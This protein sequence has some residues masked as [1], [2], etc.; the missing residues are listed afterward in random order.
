MRFVRTAGAAIVLG[1]LIGACSGGGGS[2]PG[3]TVVAAAQQQGAL[4]AARACRMWSE[5]M[6]QAVK[7]QPL[8]PTVA[9]PLDAKSAQI[10]TVANQASS[11]D[12]AWDNLATDVAGATDFASAA[13]PDINTRIVADCAKVPVDARKAAGAEPDP[14]GPTTTA[15]P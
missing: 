11:A 4:E 9:A 7:S 2:A 5:V 6:D 12:S 1:V 14:F 8:N 10:A 15:A 3:T 13:L